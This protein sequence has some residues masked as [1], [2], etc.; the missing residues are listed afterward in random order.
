VV[1]E[2]VDGHTSTV[3]VGVTGS[4]STVEIPAGGSGAATITDTYGA[5]PGSLLVTKT[6]AGPSAGH[7]GPV[8]IHVV[9]NGLALSPD[10]VIPAH[11]HAGTVS[12]SFDDVPAGS[13]CTVTETAGGAT[14]TVIVRVIGSGQ[15]VS[16]P[17]GKVTSVHVTDVYDD[18]E[19]IQNIPEEPS[20]PAV[21]AMG[22][23]TVIKHITG[24][25][26]RL[27]GRIAILVACGGTLENFTFIIPAVTGPGFVTRHF[28]QLPPEARWTVTETA[29]GGTANVSVA[30]TGTSHTVT[31]PDAGPVT[32]R[33]TD[34]F[35]IRTP[36]PPPPAVTG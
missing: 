35:T 21:D 25:A 6:I 12:H 33:L 32:V 30:A 27:H 9:C 36:P 31:I 23:L 24:P 8:T 5:T 19:P 15:T 14:A 18:G 26:A 17:A 2:T 7:E 1:T 28:D 11:T 22:I 20:S 3:S 4:P 13:T 16:V 34:T 29:T 10:F